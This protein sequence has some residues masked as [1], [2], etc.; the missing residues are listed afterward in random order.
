MCGYSTSVRRGGAR[1]R[2][3]PAGRRARVCAARGVGA[4]VV[5][6]RDRDR[7]ALVWRP[8]DGRDGSPV[9]VELGDGRRAA[10]RREGAQVPDAEGAVVGA[11]CDEV[12]DLPIRARAERRG[13]GRALTA[14]F[15]GGAAARRRGGSVG[16]AVVGTATV[17]AAV[18]ASC[19]LMRHCSMPMSGSG[20]WRWR[21]PLW[22]RWRSVWCAARACST[23]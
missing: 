5:G 4:L 14:V 18:T 23:R 15:R 19:Q 17:S 12:V 21:R 8:F 2:C 6:A 22:R 10:A 13:D 1:T 11:R 9:P 20:G 16:G 7:R 3:K